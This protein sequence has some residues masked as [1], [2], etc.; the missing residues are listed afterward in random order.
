MGFHFSHIMAQTLILL[1]STG[2]CSRLCRERGLR[3]IRHKNWVWEKPP[4]IQ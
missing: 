3:W 4:K 2:S 1:S